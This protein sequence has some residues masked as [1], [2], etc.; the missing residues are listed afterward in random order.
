ML[1]VLGWLP[2]IGPI[3]DGVVSIFSKFQDTQLGKYK[4]DGDVTVA[5]WTS[6][7]NIAIAFKDSIPVR[8]ARDIVMFPGSIWCGLYIWGRTWD[9]YAP[10]MVIPVKS[11]EGPMAYL[12]YA[13][14]T[15]FFGMAAIKR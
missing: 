6:A 7:N 8:L 15:F 2:V 10:W 14:L 3:I 12:P 1:S 11:L 5:Q 13:L 9:I 4:I